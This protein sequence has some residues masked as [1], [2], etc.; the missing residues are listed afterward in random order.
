MIDLRDNRIQS[1]DPL[2]ANLGLT[3]GASIYLVGNPI[4]CQAQA[5]NFAT[6]RGRGVAID[7]QPSR[8]SSPTTCP[9][10]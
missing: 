9:Y 7:P 3:A 8:G 5:A 6:L 2:N 4:D 10:P 1:L